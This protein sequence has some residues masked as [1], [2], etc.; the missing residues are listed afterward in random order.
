MSDAGHNWAKEQL[1]EYLVGGLSEEDRARLEAHVL[2]CPECGDDL[3]ELRKHDLSVEEPAEP[4]PPR[5]AF[6][7]RMIRSLRFSGTP[8]ALSAVARGLLAAVAVVLLGVVGFVFAEMEPGKPERLIAIDDA[9]VTVAPAGSPG[10]AG[11]EAPERPR[12]QIERR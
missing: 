7:D 2:T 5:P 1:A 9:A 10:T 3:E 4:E 11:V 12:D 8:R 6:R